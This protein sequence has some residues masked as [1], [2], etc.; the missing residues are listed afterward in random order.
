[1]FPGK[2]I[3]SIE[4][5]FLQIFVYP[6]N[7]VFNYL[8]VCNYTLTPPLYRFSSPGYPS[9]YPHNAYCEYHFK[10]PQDKAVRIYYQYFSLEASS[11]CAKDSVK[12]YEKSI[13]KATYCGYI[14]SVSWHSKESQVLM[15][16]K[17]DASITSSGFYGSFSLLTKRKFYVLC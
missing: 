15:I 1:M 14:S 2:L 8:L 5:Y 13:M 11:S 6:I 9:S 7:Y 12:L 16:F 17:S 10:V 4:S 3:C